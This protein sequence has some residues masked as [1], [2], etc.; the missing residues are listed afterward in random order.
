G[1]LLKYPDIKMVGAWGFEPQTPTVSNNAYT[2]LRQ[3]KSTKAAREVTS[4][5][6]KLI[7]FLAESAKILPKLVPEIRNRALP[8]QSRLF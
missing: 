5:L 2:F 1:K 7:K 3:Q 8:R 6:H 4:K